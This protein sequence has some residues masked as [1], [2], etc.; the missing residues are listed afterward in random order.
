[1]GK[2]KNKKVDFSS[3]NMGKN[4]IWTAATASIY[5]LKLITTDKDFDHLKEEYINLEQINIE[6]YKKT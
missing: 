5:G 2:L 4:D 3:R 6:D 1:M